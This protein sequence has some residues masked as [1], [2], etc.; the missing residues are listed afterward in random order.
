MIPT[1]RKSFNDMYEE[2][3]LLTQKIIHVP[4]MKKLFENPYAL[5]S[6]EVNQ[7]DR[8]VAYYGNLFCNDT[9]SPRVYKR[10]LAT[11]NDGLVW[12]DVSTFVPQ[13]GLL[14]FTTF[15]L[16]I[17]SNV[18]ELDKPQSDPIFSEFLINPQSII[19]NPNNISITNIQQKLEFSPSQ[20]VV[21]KIGLTSKPYTKNDNIDLNNP[22]PYEGEGISYKIVSNHLTRVEIQQAF[23]EGCGFSSRYSETNFKF[24]YYVALRIRSAQYIGYSVVFRLSYF[25]D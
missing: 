2:L 10:F 20:T 17:S 6:E 15:R 25:I 24:N 9:H 19:S 4:I 1:I 11:T 12:V 16:N 7:I 22:P 18:Y 3:L 8:V 13:L 14:N 21:L 23:L 5:S